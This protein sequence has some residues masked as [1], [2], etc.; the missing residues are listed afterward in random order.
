M[1]KILN[2]LLLLS[3][4][5]LYADG[6]LFQKANKLYA[7]EK[8]SEAILIY[9][10]ILA[11]SIESY[12]IYYNLGNCYYKQENWPYAIWNYEKSLKI[13]KNKKTIQNLHLVNLKIIDKI[14]PLPDLFYKKWWKNTENLI[15]ISLWQTLTLI[16]IWLFATL[17]ILEKSNIIQKRKINILLTISIICAS[18]TYS[19]YT[20]SI[21]KKEG[22][23]FSSTVSINSAPSEKSNS[24]FLLHSGTKIEIIDQI[25]NW[26]E[27]KIKNGNTGWI[28]KKHFKEL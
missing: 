24:L 27:I 3:S 18:F 9:D 5:N 10:S 8:Y 4:I 13:K 11:K 12:E 1:K 22:I 25:K 2:I 26:T 6:L 20:N 14:E 15:S 17:K 23:I 19:S 16:S 7:E 28:E 21:L